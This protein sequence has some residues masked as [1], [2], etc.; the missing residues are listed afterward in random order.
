MKDHFKRR[1][2]TGLLLFIPVFVLVLGL[3]HAY[4]LG[5]KVAVPVRA[6]VDVDTVFG[7]VLLNIFAILFVAFLI[8]LFGYLVELPRVATRVRRL[9]QALAAVIPGY[10]IAKGVIGGAVNDEDATKGLLP[11]V[12][13]LVDGT[14]V[15]FE[16]ER[17]ADGKS[18]VYLPDAPSA[19]TG[20]V[21]VFDSDRVDRLNVP[22]HRIFEALSFHG[23]GIL[24]LV[25]Q[26]GTS[27]DKSDG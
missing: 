8:Y 5:K 2:I 11:V 12:V 14:R 22:P 19:R 9:D 10:N 17:N 7:L 26:S 18:V 24:G 1:F 23:R 16:V 27:A 3:V 20:L 6:A 21:M 4:R 15:G 13:Q 25:A